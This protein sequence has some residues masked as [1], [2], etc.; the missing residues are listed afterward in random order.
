MW[1][2]RSRQSLRFGGQRFTVFAIAI[3]ALCVPFTQAQSSRLP[4]YQFFAQVSEHSQLPRI[5]VDT[6][7]R[8]PRLEASGTA[9][10]DVLAALGRTYG[11]SLVVDQ[12]VSGILNLRIDSVRLNDLFLFIAKE[13]ELVWEKTGELLKVSKAPPPEP[14]PGLLS[15]SRSADRY[16][17]E[18]QGVELARLV[19]SLMDVSNL[20]VVI[21][22]DRNV[23]ID[24]RVV[25]LTLLDALQ[26]L[27]SPANLDVAT[28]GEVLVI[29]RKSDESGAG[30]GTR[31]QLACAD[32]ILSFQA[33]NVSLQQVIQR[34]SQACD[35]GITTQGQLDGTVNATMSNV[36]VEEA[37]VLI[38]TGTS[39]TYQRVGDVLIVGSIENRD[40]Q[41]S[42]MLEFDYLIAERVEPIIPAVLRDRVSIKT[43]KEQNALLVTG[44]QTAITQLELF[45]QEIDIPVAQVLFEVLVVDYNTTD[46]S[47]FRLFAN[48]FGGDSVSANEEYFPNVDVNW[49]GSQLNRE[50]A[51][52]SDRLSIAT[53]GPLPD[54]FFLRLQAM[55]QEGIANIRSQPQIASLNGHVAS[56]IIG[57]TQYFLLEDATTFPGDQP[58][59]RTSQ[60]FVTI[61]ADM[62]LEITPF[63]NR[64]GDLVVEVMPEFNT[65]VGEFTSEIPPTINRRQLSSTVRLRDGETIVLGGLVETNVVRTIDKFPILGS[66]PLIGSLFQNRSTVEQRSDL[67]I[68]VTPRVYFGSEA[69]ID[70]DSL[71]SIDP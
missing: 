60:R 52:L 21:N 65:P 25:S 40:L 19:D 54:N 7:I 44:P 39:Y 3:C 38:L 5:L 26:A 16:S 55:V 70:R 12:S 66:L 6:T 61:E 67:M 35:V 50:L 49:T 15:I 29:E 43:I 2:I 41:A 53:L 1:L 36:T 23:L 45:I 46:R 13:Q 18:A 22:A 63:V 59:T 24:G 10:R 34:L 17:I 42:R 31:L 69:A 14:E 33:T 71:L 68:Y 9:T 48:N 37:L 57:T 28:Q 56:I 51:S 20:T 27:L 62:K 11:I 58:T 8:V 47:T 64:S 30:T 4:D 32:G